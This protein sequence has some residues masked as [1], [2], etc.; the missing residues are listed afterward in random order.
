MSQRVALD[1]AQCDRGVTIV[2][3]S[4]ALVFDGYH[5]QILER[6]STPIADSDWGFIARDERGLYG[7]ATRRKAAYRGDQGEW[8]NDPTPDQAS[9]V[10]SR[11]LFAYDDGASTPRWQYHDGALINTT[12]TLHD[13]K[14]FFL[15]AR[16]D[17]LADRVG[18]APH[19][20]LQNVFL[21]A[22]DA[23]TGKTVWERAFD[24]PLGA[25]VTYLS[26]ADGTLL[27]TNS[28]AQRAFTLS[29][30]DTRDG[31]PLWNHTVAAQKTHHSGWL[32]HPVLLQGKIHVNKHTYDLRT[33]R[34]LRVDP[35]DYHGCGIMAASANAIFHR[36]EFH[37]MLDLETG[38]RTEFLG[39][40][41]GCWLGQIPAGGLLLAPESS[42][43]CSCAHALQTSMAFA[44]R[45]VP[46][47][48]SG[49]PDEFIDRAEITLSTNVADG[50]IRVSTDGS[51]VTRAS[52]LYTQALALTAT[53]TVTARAYHGDSAYGSAVRATWRRVIPRPAV[54]GT[55]DLQPGLTLTT[56]RG[57]WKEVPDWDDHQPT[58][59]LIAPTIDLRQRPAD[60]PLGARLEGYLTVDARDFYEFEL[61]SDGG[62]RLT[63]GEHLVMALSGT[64]GKE[65][66]TGRVALDRGPHRLRIDYF[67]APDSPEPRAR[68]NSDPKRARIL[69]LRM[70]TPAAA[71]QLIPSERLSHD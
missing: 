67:D 13:G 28:D 18:R 22:L 11:V 45:E 38:E 41:G 2:Q 54:T 63:L 48:F 16:A 49:S 44:P 51:D 71:W 25:Y 1:V 61:T 64:H 40:R 47:E 6:Y 3:G 53:T 62:T 58:E 7:T 12:I 52:P 27:V 5:G 23:G 70:R 21:V 66:R 39:V 65:T 46:V 57:S 59:T 34:V 4:S 42:A 56:Y 33:G 19:G 14:V 37:G 36:Y 69:Q 29:A 15:E 10:L 32:H 24:Q 17:G 60:D 43:G 50:T 20:E 26:C 9:R 8:Y 31:A 35:F 68:G 30:H 55:A